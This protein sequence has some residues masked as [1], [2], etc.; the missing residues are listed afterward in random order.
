MLV[1]GP[2]TVVAVAYI[3]PGNFGA[4]IEAG[5]KYGLSLLW[6]VWLSGLMAVMFQY[7]SGKIG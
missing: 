2:A 4:N 1:I 5:S 7:I 3:D 6:V